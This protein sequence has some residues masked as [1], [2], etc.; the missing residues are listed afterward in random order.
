MKSFLTDILLPLSAV[1]AFG[2]LTLL[3]LLYFKQPS[4]IFYPDLPSREIETT[5]DRVG[6]AYEEVTLSTE[7][8]IKLN[9]WYLP[10]DR[11]RATLLFF[12]G[13]AGNISHRLESILLFNRLQLTVMIID[14]RGYGKSEGRMSEQGSYRDAKA[15]WRYLT[16]QRGIAPN[17]ILVFGR[18]LGASIAAQL[19]SQHQ[20]LG[21]ILESAF[22]SVPDLAADLYPIFPV[23]HLSRFK[24]DTRRYLE[25]SKSP[26]LIMH[27]RHDEITP[28]SHGKKLLDSASEPKR[29]LELKGGHNDGFLASGKSYSSAWNGFIELCLSL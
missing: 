28:F 12:H 4:L 8:G 21:L 18:S 24:F 15:A 11:P 9:G 27:S 16:E 29:F 6:L 22:T 25:G 1:V 14:Y 20:P 5:P 26:V 23:R 13:N 10:V 17:Q 7:D 2:Y 3:A 19:A